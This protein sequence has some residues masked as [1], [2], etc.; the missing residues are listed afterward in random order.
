MNNLPARFEIKDIETMANVSARSGLFGVKDPIQAMALMLLCEAEGLHPMQACV[1][2]HIIQGRASMASQTVMALFM[3][4]N[5]RQEIH[6]LTDEVADITL[7][8]PQ[9][10][11]ARIKWTMEQARKAGLAGK[12]NWKNHPRSMLLRR[13]QAEGVRAVA[14]FVLQG[15]AVEDEL[16]EVP[17]ASFPSTKPEL[18][19]SKLPAL[20]APLAPV[21]IEVPLDKSWS[22][23][24]KA[25]ATKE[26]RRLGGSVGR[27]AIA[28]IP[29]D[30]AVEFEDFIAATL[31]R[32]RTD[33]DVP[34]AD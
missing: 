26:A 15:M 32:L 9:G 13:A 22:R 7:S 17:T 27:D 4:A 18:D 31:K 11:T 2:Y 25:R 14:P 12:D 8:H 28:R 34:P 24:I 5:G 6:E 30:R 29:E 21:L 33:D 19:I 23:E 20:D 10:G 1:R 3:A 16:E